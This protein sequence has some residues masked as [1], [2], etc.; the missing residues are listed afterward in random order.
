MT[1]LPVESAGRIFDALLFAADVLGIR[2]NDAADARLA[3]IEQKLSKALSNAFARSAAEVISEAM[4]VVASE[5]ITADEIEGLVNAA[6]TRELGAGFAAR[7]VPAVCK[8]AR[9]AVSTGVELT[10]SGRP[11]PALPGPAVPP[12]AP[13]PVPSP[14]PTPAEKRSVGWLVGDTMYWVGKARNDLTFSRPG[15]DGK[16]VQRTLGQFVADTAIAGRALGKSKEQIAAELDAALRDVVG[17][18][19]RAHWGVVAVSATTRGGSLGAIAA[20]ESAGVIALRWVSVIDDRTTPICRAMDGRIIPIRDLQALRSAAFSAAD[21]EQFKDAWPWP[22][23]ASVNAALSAGGF[24]QGVVAPP[25]HANCRSRLEPA[26]TG[27]VLPAGLPVAEPVRASGAKIPPGAFNGTDPELFETRKTKGVVPGSLV[28][29]TPVRANGYG[30]PVVF[31]R[32]DLAGRKIAQWPTADPPKGGGWYWT[33]DVEH[34]D[35]GKWRRSWRGA[36]SSGAISGGEFRAW[37]TRALGRA[38]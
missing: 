24:P 37:L 31:E 15:P 18:K 38:P 13:A 32:G 6:A 21:E 17:P 19:S 30:E 9:S 33:A 20:A 14:L 26:E 2:R 35:G 1:E 22:T 8:A 7:V 12:R 25:A 4:G 5:G 3:R 11:R 16:P 23:D 36:A 27:T 29:V 34:A 28:G 10:A